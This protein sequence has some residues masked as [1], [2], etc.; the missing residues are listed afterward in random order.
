MNKITFI[1]LFCTELFAAC[2]HNHKK[3]MDQNTLTSLPLNDKI[4]VAPPDNT[5]NSQPQITIILPQ[6]RSKRID[7]ASNDEPLEDRIANFTFRNGSTTPQILSTHDSLNS[8][9]A[10]ELDGWMALNADLTEIVPVL[11][12]AD[13][14]STEENRRAF[15]NEDVVNWEAVAVDPNVRLSPY[16]FRGFP[17]ELGKAGPVINANCL[18]VSFDVVDI[19]SKL[20]P[21]FMN[22]QNCDLHFSGKTVRVQ[23]GP[24]REMVHIPN[25]RTLHPDDDSHTEIRVYDHGRFVRA[26]IHFGIVLTADINSDGIPDFWT[27]L[28]DDY[29]SASALF[30]SKTENGHL[31]EYVGAVRYNPVCMKENNTRERLACNKVLSNHPVLLVQ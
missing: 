23:T 12:T 20:K 22:V 19:R 4:S 15:E 7:P 28:G 18:K 29:H 21:Q 6:M 16:V 30:M 31:L 25:Y 27:D 2:A 5:E 3:I 24:V 10:N 9:P 11:L 13:K 8:E 26:A 17:A 14:T 1:L